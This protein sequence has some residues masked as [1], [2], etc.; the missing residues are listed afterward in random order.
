[1]FAELNT[2]NNEPE[3]S[4]AIS[5]ARTPHGNHTGILAKYKNEIKFYH[6]AW[7]LELLCD[8][9]EEYIANNEN[10]LLKRWVKFMMLTSDPIIASYR[11]PSIIKKLE[12]ILEKSQGKIPYAIN[13]NT[14]TF[15]DDGN[16]ILGEQEN[17]LTCSTFIASFF[18]SVAINLVDLT[19]WIS[20][21]E[22][23]TN[24]KRSITQLMLR[25]NVSFEHVY[26][27]AKEPLNFRLKPE[28]VAASSS[29]PEED[30]PA[31]FHFCSTQGAAFNSL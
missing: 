13:F 20:R 10:Y 17:G 4:L 2:F 18:N 16:L 27:V 6:L 26:N 7:H 25:T 31:N 19:T 23:D 5:V 29:L 1:M 30:L 28:E 11:I 22:E 24:W 9:W 14:T 21:D 8:N 12:M 3:F 15:T